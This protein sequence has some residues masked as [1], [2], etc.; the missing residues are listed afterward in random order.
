[1]AYGHLFVHRDLL[2]QVRRRRGFSIRSLAEKAKA[3]NSTISAI[4]TGE[5]VS[6]SRDLAQRVAKA[7]GVDVDLLFSASMVIVGDEEAVEEVLG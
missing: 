2:N 7:L 4:C 3:S 5:R 1:M 6:V